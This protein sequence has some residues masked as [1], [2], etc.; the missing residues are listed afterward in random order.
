MLGSPLAKSWI[1]YWMLTIYVKQLYNNLPLLL[2]GGVVEYL[3]A[4]PSRNSPLK[5]SILIYPYEFLS[6]PKIWDI[7]RKAPLKCYFGQIWRANQHF[8]KQYNHWNGKYLAC[9]AT[10]GFSRKSE[11]FHGILWKTYDF[12]EILQKLKKIPKG[13]TK[14]IRFSQVLWKLQDFYRVFTRV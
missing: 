3:I 11:Y 12:A 4:E 9:K 2:T 6:T 13:F 5:I 14:T 10:T 1:R 8:I 7:S